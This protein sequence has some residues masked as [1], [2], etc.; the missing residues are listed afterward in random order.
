MTGG[1]NMMLPMNSVLLLI[2]ILLAI[3]N[4]GASFNTPILLIM[5]SL[6]AGLILL[7]VWYA[8]GIMLDDTIGLA[9]M[10][11]LT[12]VFLIIAIVGPKC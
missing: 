7:G 5:T 10:A 4:T 9:V 8:P 12:V 3:H 11:I 2:I 1:S 6:F